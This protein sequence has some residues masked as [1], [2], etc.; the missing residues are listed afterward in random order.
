MGYMK[1]QCFHKKARSR[2]DE[3]R[4]PEREEIQFMHRQYKAHLPGS[5]CFIDVR[6]HGA[7]FSIKS[8]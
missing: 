4:S 8:K 7:L 1:R 3:P 2:N 5:E 6:P